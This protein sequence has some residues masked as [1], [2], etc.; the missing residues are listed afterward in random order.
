M[1]AETIIHNKVY[2]ALIANDL[3][4]DAAKAWAYS[5]VK[6]YKDGVYED[7]DELISGNI[8]FASTGKEL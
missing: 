8:H 2:K 4:I 3:P 1:N 7:L 5:T 6:T